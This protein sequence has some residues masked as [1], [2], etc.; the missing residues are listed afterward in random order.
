MSG[1]VL[2]VLLALVRYSSAPD[3]SSCPAGFKRF[4]HPFVSLCYPKGWHGPPPANDFDGLQLTLMGG[5]SVLFAVDVLPVSSMDLPPTMLHREQAI[6]RYAYENGFV[7]R[8]QLRGLR[9]RA[10]GANETI[11]N[12]GW[13][14][15]HRVLQGSTSGPETYDFGKFYQTQVPVAVGLTTALVND[16]VVLLTQVI[17]PTSPEAYQ[18]TIDAF[19]EIR[20]TMTF[21]TVADPARRDYLFPTPL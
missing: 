19:R 18:R 3:P 13:T 5:A 14:L 9:L 10:S 15:R 21:I 17:Y 12:N 1:V 8:L 6:D 2:A 16:H 20:R 7:S 11:D 4:T